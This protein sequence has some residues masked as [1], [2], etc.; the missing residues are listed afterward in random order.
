ME[1]QMNQ[2]NMDHYFNTTGLT[3]QTLANARSGA[4]KQEEI[5]M[6][7]FESVSRS[8]PSQMFRHIKS[9]G[10]NWPITSI[11]RAM[12]NLSS[13]GRLQRTFMQIQGMY[14]KPEYVWELRRN[15][16]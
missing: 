11:R 14:G 16:A 6:A 15:D 3:G 4:I 7:I 13:R 8:S 10:L 2:E 1:E 9:I 12:T 5:I